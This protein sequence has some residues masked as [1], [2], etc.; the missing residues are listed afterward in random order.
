MKQASSKNRRQ[1]NN[2]TTIA[3]TSAEHLNFRKESSNHFEYEGDIK[4]LGKLESN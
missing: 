1:F 2:S 4:M 3:E